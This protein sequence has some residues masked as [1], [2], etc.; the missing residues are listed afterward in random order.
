MLTPPTGSATLQHD[1]IGN[2]SWSHFNGGYAHQSTIVPINTRTLDQTT[3]L[4]RNNWNNSW[5][6]KSNHTNGANFVF[7]DGS[8]KFISQ[9]IDMTAY[10]LLGGRN[11][12]QP[13]PNY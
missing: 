4:Q 12:G 6:F 7:A 1:H 10:Q 5:G 9:S 8:V 11:D 2:G 13:I 3:C